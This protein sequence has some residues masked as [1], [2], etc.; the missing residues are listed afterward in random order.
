MLNIV[1]DLTAEG[2]FRHVILMI[3]ENNKTQPTH[4]LNEETNSSYYIKTCM[5]YN[6][7][8]NIHRR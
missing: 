4:Q 2:A 6:R 1:Y 7:S 5:N 8:Q 3:N